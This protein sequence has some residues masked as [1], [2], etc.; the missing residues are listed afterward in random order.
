MDARNARIP[1]TTDQRCTSNDHREIK[2]ALL[3]Q[4]RMVQLETA[5]NA[6]GGVVTEAM[7]GVGADWW[8]NIDKGAEKDWFAYL[9]DLQYPAG[10]GGGGEMTTS[11]AS[12]QAVQDAHHHHHHRQALKP[13]ASSARFLHH[14]G[15]GASSRDGLL[16]NYV[17]DALRPQ[18]PFQSTGRLVSIFDASLDKYDKQFSLKPVQISP[19]EFEKRKFFQARKNAPVHCTCNDGYFGTCFGSCTCSRGTLGGKAHGSKGKGHPTHHRPGGGG[20]L[21]PHHHAGL[22]PKAGKDGPGGTMPGGGMA[23]AGSSGGGAHLGP[24]RCSGGVAKQRAVHYRGVR[25]RPWGKWAAE[26][27]DPRKGVRLWL[28]TF[29]TAKEAALKYDEAARKIRG[30]GAKV[31]FPARGGVGIGED[32]TTTTTTTTTT[33]EEGNNTVIANP[34]ELKLSS[35]ATSIAE[36]NARLVFASPPVS[37]IFFA[38]ILSLSLSLSLFLQHKI[39]ETVQVGIRGEQRVGLT[40]H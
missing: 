5:K 18:A 36:G 20:G 32:E 33:S 21:S 39:K 1:T 25:R 2:G 11:F 15:G 8:N 23:M 12:P 7:Q 28:G 22:G 27:R 37:S 19:E 29:N 3:Q 35:A 14:H 9:E 13:A 10:Q 26:I 24:R 38:D 4:R 30:E 6:G 17:Y 34:A 40:K 31:N 16:E